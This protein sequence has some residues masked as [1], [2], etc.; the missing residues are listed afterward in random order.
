MKRYIFIFICLILFAAFGTLLLTSCSKETARP[1]YV[2]IHI[3]ADSNAEE[4]QNVKLAVR[5]SVVQYLTPLALSVKDKEGMLKMINERKREIKKVADDSLSSC[6]FSY[7]ANVRVAREPFPTR[8][9]GDLTLQNGVYDA[10]IIELGSGE[11]NN[12]WCVAFPPLCFLASKETGKEEV[13]YRSWLAK[14]FN[15]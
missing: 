15:R 3:R 8:T 4:D 12:W 7:E 10:V 13:R 9:Y 2:R 11:G 6:G 14:L 5:D 1:D